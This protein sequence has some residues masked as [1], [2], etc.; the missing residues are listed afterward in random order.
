MKHALEKNLHLDYDLTTVSTGEE[1]LNEVEKQKFDLL[2]LDY[3]LPA[4]TGIELLNEFQKRKI[5]SPII[6]VTS[7]GSEKI[8]VEAIKLGAIDY[9]VKDDITTNRLIESIHEIITKASLPT[10]VDV[11]TANQIA[12]LFE[13]SSIIQTD[14]VATLNSAPKSNIPPEKMVSALNKMAEVGILK[15]E[16]SR[17]V[18]ACPSCGSVTASLRL[19]CPDCGDVQLRKGEALE[20][21]PCGHVDFGSQFDKGEGELVCPKCKKKLKMIGVDYRRIK[22]WY[23]CSHNHFF[24]QPT[25]GFNCYSCKKDFTKEDALLEMLQEYQ[26]TDKGKDMLRLGLLGQEQTGKDQ[27]NELTNAIGAL[28]EQ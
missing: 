10:E 15:A 12:K 25:T 16:P 6:F 20:H 3:R 21:F 23:K 19:K 22:S 14:V 5:T 17:S 7:K 9:I 2:L 28:N 18:V 24:G 11:E 27:K 8:A 1:G 26:L 13:E 4:M